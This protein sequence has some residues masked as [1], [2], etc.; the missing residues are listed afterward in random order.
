MEKF[1]HNKILGLLPKEKRYLVNEGNGFCLRISV[2][3]TKTWFYRYKFNGKEKWLTIGH[4]PAMGVAEAR[5]RFN[6]YWGM[7]SS[8]QDPEQIAM[9]QQIQKTNTVQTLITEW[10]KHY[11]LKHRKQPQQI[12]QQIDAD[13]IP[14]LGKLELNKLQTRD[15]TRALD[16]IVKRGAPVHANKV[17][18]TLKQVFNYAVNRGELVANPAASLRARDIGGVEKPKERYLTLDELKTLW[19]FLESEQHGLSLSI[20]QAIKIIILTGVRTAEI[21]LATWSEFDF[22]QSLWIIPP[23]HTKTAMTMKIHLT[24]QVK[25][26]LQV[27]QQASSSEYVLTG[28]DLCSCLSE[29]AISKAISRIQERVGIPYW[30]AHDLRRTFATQLGEAL[31]VDPVVIE[32]C[33]GHKMPKIM[34]TYNKNE[35]LHQRK[36]A[37]NRWGELLENLLSTSILPVLGSPKGSSKSSPKIEMNNE[38]VACT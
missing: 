1:T 14:L 9:E 31:H 7:R 18:S 5:K 6:E 19:L 36:D 30:T 22:D 12:K 15:I 34:A 38:V 13:I 28:S 2:Q 23:A 20:T 11:I 32:K 21:R 4:F 24:S 16:S 8:G 3:G 10:Y 29:K 33:L 35:M 26:I 27:L 17:L 25:S 37:L